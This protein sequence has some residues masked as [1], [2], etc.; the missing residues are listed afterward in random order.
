VSLLRTT[1]S[2]AWPAACRLM[3]GKSLLPRRPQERLC[4]RPS[5]ACL[6]RVQQV[7]VWIHKP[8]QVGRIQV[9]LHLHATLLVIA[10]KQIS[11]H[12][13]PSAGL[14]MSM[15]PLQEPKA[16]LSVPHLRARIRR[17]EFIRT[18]CKV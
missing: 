7:G 10:F 3:G 15:C 9:P 18:V 17:G 8:N 11:Y 16:P 12:T 1:G 2:D 5:L 4:T 13:I 6:V 14:G